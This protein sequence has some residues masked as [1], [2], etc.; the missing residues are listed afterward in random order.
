MDIELSENEKNILNEIHLK[1]Y[2]I[3]SLSDILYILTFREE[4]SENLNLFLRIEY[5]TLLKIKRVE[6]LNLFRG[7]EIGKK[8]LLN[9]TQ[10]CNNDYLNARYYH[11]LFYI[12]K[13]LIFAKKA[14]D[15]YFQQFINFV[16]GKTFI[17]T[18]LDF[19]L[20]FYLICELIDITKYKEIEFKKF[21]HDSLENQSNI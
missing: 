13:D 16:T 19:K 7:N 10:N 6:F 4:F 11:F 17:I 15:H 21:I 20:V 18:D 8:Y 9:R 12:T 3:S 14:V 1:I 2:Q 5:F